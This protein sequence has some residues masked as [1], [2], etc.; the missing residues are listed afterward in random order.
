MNFDDSIIPDGPAVGVPSPESFPPASSVSSPPVAQPQSPIGPL[1]P[2]GPAAAFSASVPASDPVDFREFGDVRKTRQRIYDNVLKAVENLEPISNSRYTLRLSN[3]GYADPDSFSKKKQKEAILS[4]LSLGRR[5]R[6]TWELVDNASGEVIDNRT[7]VLM[8]VP[9]LTERGTYIN[10]GTEYG[11]KNQQRLLPGVYTRQQENGDIESYVNV[12]P[13]KGV[14]HRYYL[15]P[16]KGTFRIKVGQGHVNLMPLLRVFGVRDSELEEAW[17]RDLLYANLKADSESERN[18]LYSKFLSE[19]EQEAE[20]PERQRLLRAKFEAMGFDP[21]VNRRTLGTPHEN[22]SKAAILDITRKLLKVHRQEADPDDRDSLVYQQ[23]L[24]PEDLFAERISRDKGGLRRQLLW[25]MTT[26]GNLSSM[27]SS[28]LDKQVKAALLFSGLGESLEEVNPAQIY[29]KLSAVSRVGEGGISS[30]DAIPVESRS[31]QPSMLGFVDPVRTPESGKVGVDVYLTRSARKGSDGK[32]YSSFLDAKTGELVYRTPQDL[33]DLTVA[34]QGAFDK[35]G[36]RVVAM[37]GGEMDYVAKDE[38]D[39]IVPHM[40]DAFNP[41]SNI[42]PM[43]QAVKGQRLVMASRMTTQALPLVHA[44]APL[45]QSAVPGTN[46]EQSFEEL[47]SASLGTIRAEKGGVVTDIDDEGIHVTY[48]DGTTETHDLYSNF[49]LNRKTALHQTPLVQPGQRIEPNQVLARS[50]Y[51]DPNGTLALGTNARTAYMAWEGKNFEDAI[52]ISEGFAKRTAS[53][54]MYQHQ[55]ELGDKTKLGKKEFISQFPGTYSKEL[56]S[57][58]DEQGVIKLGTEV[59]YGDPL[60]LGLQ[61]KEL[62]HN[63]VHKSKQQAWGD[64][65][66]TWDHHDKGIVTDV[67][68]S[69]NGPVVAVK[70]VSESRVGD[71]FCYDPMTE[72]LTR[73]GWKLIGKVSTMD[74]IA[75]LNPE[76]G[77]IEWSPVAAT[78]SYPHIGPMYRLRT[79]QVDLFVTDNHELFVKQE[80]Q[81]RYGLAKASRVY[82]TNFR[83]KKNGWWSGGEGSTHVVISASALRSVAST[84][85]LGEPACNEAASE[86]I[87]SKRQ[88]ASVLGLFLSCGHHIRPDDGECGIEFRVSDDPSRQLAINDLREAGIPFVES[89]RSLRITDPI[90]VSHLRQF[91]LHDKQKRI[92]REVFEWRRELLVVLYARLTCQRDRGELSYVYA[93]ESQQLADDLQQLCLMIDLSA[94]V[95]RRRRA[96]FE[97]NE[98]DYVVRIRTAEHEPMIGST[99]CGGSEKQ[100]EAWV[101]YSGYVHC[102]TLKRNHVLYVRRNGLAVW[103]GNSGRYGDK[104]VVADIVPDHKMPKDKDGNPYDVLLNPAGLLTRTNAA[105]MAELWLGKIAQRNGKPIKVEDFRTD[106]DLTEWV[107]QLLQEEGLSPYDDLEDPTTGRKIRNIATGNRFVMKLHHSAESKVQGR[108]GGGYTAEGLPAKVGDAKSKRVGMLESNALLSHGAYETLADVS[109]I[110]GQRNDEFW[111]QFMQGHNPKVTKIP[112]VYEKFVA[113]LKAAGVNVVSD[114]P[115][116]HIMALTDRDITQLAG[117]REITT[118]EGVDWGE[119][120]KERRGGF[121]DRSKTGGHGGGSWSYFKLA[122]PMPNPVMEEPIR[123]MLGLT[124]KKFDAVIAGAE[125]LPR[126]GSGPQAI[127]AALKEIDLDKEIENVRNVIASG[128]K[129]FRDDAVR[130]LGYLKSA[131][132]LGLHPS[133]YVLTKVPVLPPQFRPVSLM[134]DDMPL[135]DDANYLYKELFEANAN[136]GKAISRLGDKNAGPEAAATYAAFKAVVGLGDPIGQKTKEKEVRGILKHVFGTNPKYGTMQRKLLST[137]VDNVGRAVISPNPD[138]DMDSIGIPEE[139]AFDVYERFV[140]RQ[141]VRRGMSVRQ[142]REEI[143]NKTRVAK[144]ALLMEM[145]RRPVYASR[146]PVLHKFG[147]LAFKPRLVK[148]STLQVSPLIVKGFNADFDGNCVTG[149]TVVTLRIDTNAF[150][151]PWEGDWCRQLTACA[152]DPEC[153]FVTATVDSTLLASLPIGNIPRFGTPRIDKNGAKVYA[154]PRGVS[155]VTYDHAQNDVSFAPTTLYTVEDEH[156]CVEVRTASGRKLRVSDNESVAVYDCGSDTLIKVRPQ[157]AVGKLVP[158]IK[159]VRNAEDDKFTLR[160][161]QDIASLFYSNEITRTEWLTFLEHSSEPS[162]FGFFLELLSTSGVFQDYRRKPFSPKRGASCVIELFSERQVEDCMRFATYIGIDV[163]RGGRELCGSQSTD[164][165]LAWSVADIVDRVPQAVAES[166]GVADW[167]YSLAVYGPPVWQTDIVPL[168]DEALDT[169]ER[170]WKSTEPVPWIEQAR[171]SGFAT[172]S[173]A[174]IALLS[175]SRRTGDDFPDVLRRLVCVVK[176]DSVLW[177]PV[178]TVSPLP[179]QPVFDLVV[180]DSKVFMVENGLIVYDT[181]NFHVP[182]SEAAVREAYDK[183]LPSKNLFSLSDLRSVAHAPI[184]EFVGG[185]Y[186]ASSRR[187]RSERPERTFRTAADAERAYAAGEIAAND[188]VRI[189]EE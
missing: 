40:E 103:C 83:V 163:R 67:V 152:A 140:T 182:T 151:E 74:Q 100:R 170:I 55:L 150:R 24:G 122:Q 39:L 172:R 27:P 185:L 70:T 181:M 126:H 144:E 68:M 139:Q 155:I 26:K 173:S 32:I 147:I 138:M 101:Q 115:K 43:K 94:D 17:G 135:V 167:W 33:A 10:E 84:E 104:G 92:P 95:R 69:R 124:Q 45:V 176:K 132:H 29:D 89:V 5:L 25:K 186:Y 117:D 109:T 86:L 85:S 145:E 3:I 146:A 148:S 168:C 102:V 49:A 91:A 178:E 180:P 23:F 160:D 87:V 171:R 9:H 42:I 118:A 65:S 8:T 37:R 61:R 90:W 174:Q 114:G 75:S 189:L 116:N 133:D 183:L 22:L 59:N 31:V 107:Q 166:F 2:V 77:G 66:V 82:G 187:L 81:D 12:L 79:P 52:V 158:R 97:A 63:K 98:H 99:E 188:I 30:V 157:D 96:H 44:E 54:H 72:V 123:R 36:K 19:A 7:Q 120:L 153:G 143:M 156:S 127:A 113:Q 184:N 111:L 14:S 175:A 28:S 177:D 169:F 58:F 21:D 71:K 13:G 119:K 50:N 159:R 47:Y 11:L 125:E 80:E 164:L 57:N 149:E 128:R 20:E 154:L 62:T 56:L 161:G 129:S 93:T 60:I 130:R 106:R 142:A 46:G 53:E 162:R 110:R 165:C 16:E 64:A 51:S 141:L 136:Y 112:H 35:P 134:G 131:K 41:L 179:P 6:G 88:Y 121:F 108:G 78:H 137:T 18:K 4:G 73:D 15:D 1:P 48:D 34:F 105:Q 76:S 38:I